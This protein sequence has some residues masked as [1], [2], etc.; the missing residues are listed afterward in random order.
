MNLDIFIPYGLD[1][2]TVSSWKNL[3]QGPGEVNIPSSGKW[4]RAGWRERAVNRE[5][6][7][8]GKDSPRVHKPLDLTRVALKRG[9]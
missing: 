1:D 6:Q 8:D 7:G 9:L 2:I 3:N 5:G 4:P